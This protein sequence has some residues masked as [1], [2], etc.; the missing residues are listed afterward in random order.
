MKIKR[1]CVSFTDLKLCFA[2]QVHLA[3]IRQGVLLILLQYLY[4]GTCFFPRDD[5]NL[6]TEVW[7]AMLL[8][9]TK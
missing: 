2:M 9:N 1:V 4:T 7:P 3:E 6:G 5:L 8:S